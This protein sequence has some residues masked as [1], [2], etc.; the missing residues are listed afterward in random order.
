LT[1]KRTCTE[2]SETIPD[3]NG[4]PVAGSACRCPRTYD[5]DNMTATMIITAAK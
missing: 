2:P 5:K 4:A 1:D 3:S